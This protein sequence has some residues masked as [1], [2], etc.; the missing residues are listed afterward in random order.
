VHEFRCIRFIFGALSAFVAFG[1]CFFYGLSW[2]AASASCKLHSAGG[3]LD[4]SHTMKKYS[5]GIQ[6]HGLALSEAIE[7][8]AYH[9]NTRRLFKM[10]F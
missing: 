2:G 8:G 3:A 4:H 10:H 5:Y 6:G 1:V 7:K 9:R